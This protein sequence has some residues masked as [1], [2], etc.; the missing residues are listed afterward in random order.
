[1]TM[2]LSCKFVGGQHA[3]GLILTTFVVLMTATWRVNLVVTLIASIALTIDLTFALVALS[4]WLVA[5]V[6]NSDERSVQRRAHNATFDIFL[7]IG[8]CVLWH[9]MRLTLEI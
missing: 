2:V 4:T 7:G 3:Y 9:L 6:L 1:M 8:V 5:V